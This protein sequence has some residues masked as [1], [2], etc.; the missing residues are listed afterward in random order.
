MRP[1]LP[2]TR[3]TLFRRYSVYLTGLVSAVLVTS[4]SITLYFSYVELRALL[5][6]SQREKLEIATQRI[7]QFVRDIDTLSRAALRFGH[8]APVQDAQTLR[9]ELIRLLRQAPAISEATW[10]DAD[11]RQA[12]EVSR[13][14]VDETAP[15][16]DLSADPAVIGARRDRHY[17]GPVSFRRDS[18]PY[19]SFAFSEG[20][21]RRG[22]EVLIADVNLKL[23]R[24]FLSGLK[25]ATSR[26]AFV[27]DS[28]GQ[29]IAHRDMERVLRKTSLAQRPQ[30]L[31]AM[32]A[33][34]TQE[35]TAAI[36]RQS[37]T[38]ERQLTLTT[39]QAIPALGWHVFVEQPMQEA[40]APLIGAAER[41]LA[42]LAFGI[43]MS[44]LAALALARQLSRPIHALSEGAVRLGEGRLEARVQIDSGD[45]LQELADRF[46]RM[47]DRLGESQEE[48]EARIAERTGEL[49]R[50]N[51]AQARFLAAASHDL[52][53]PTHALGLYVAQLKDARNPVERER[54][55]GRIEA[56]S[57][58]VS[59]LLDALF[60]LSKLDAGK[61][62][63]A[64][65]VVAVQTLLNR[66]EQHFSL[67]AQGKG[68]Q[69]RV[70]PCTLC[71]RVDPLLLERVLMNLV[72][73]AVRH[74]AEGGVLVGCRRRG[75]ALRI[76]VWDSGIGIPAAEQALVFD[77]FY[78]ASIPV[79]DAAKGLGLG[80][81]IV[82][83]IALLLGAPILLRSTLGRGSLFAIDVPLSNEMPAAPVGTSTE[84]ALSTRFDGATALLVDD[85]DAARDAAAGL[86]QRWGWTIIAAASPAQAMAL[87]KSLPQA[88]TAI[89]TDYRLG[90]QAL[91]TTLIE[92][93][94]SHYAL[95]IPA[96]IV[97]GESPELH[98]LPMPTAA[99]HVLS[100]PLQPAQLRAVLQHV[101]TL[102]SPAFSAK[103]RLAGQPG[104]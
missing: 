82:R 61:I 90:K 78:Q 9:A 51:E 36:W 93:V 76:G 99:T 73:N 39:H 54:L 15:G 45:E 65:R 13:T 4:S 38:G 102:G 68:L 52:R 71:V 43:V 17:A 10:V 74:T 49:A 40:F 94:R 34:V 8:V 67:A 59:Q 42:L 91:G 103:E 30:V 88:P 87:I 85:D 64:P 24:E 37:V 97:T 25:V 77:E 11:G 41:A 96:V 12:A 63:P 86:L 14:D 31:A 44:S 89:I 66:L 5:E 18:E 60:D 2:A 7:D 20:D 80:L 100:K 28:V 104:R 19:M 92:A 81:A 26:D 70:R 46:N 56:S 35:P 22:R 55:L 48:L 32:Q 98:P 62:E 58:A 84:S 3:R 50:A 79:G 29:L 6:N 95:Q 83:R 21:D 57:T 53:Q 69:M 23:V 1:A 27:V 33:P 75:E 16:R 101:M 72:S 47:A